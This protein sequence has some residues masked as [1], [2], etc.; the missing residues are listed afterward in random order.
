MAKNEMK[1]YILQD[2]EN[3]MEHQVSL[4]FYAPVSFTDD[5]FEVALNNAKAKYPGEWST[6]EI[7]NEL[8]A[9]GCEM[10]SDWNTVWF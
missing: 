8:V 5:D 3:R 10:V 4:V 2:S 7:A 1:L 6:E 9:M